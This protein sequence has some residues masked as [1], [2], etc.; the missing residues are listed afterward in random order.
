MSAVLPR[1]KPNMSEVD[2]S[3][4]ESQHMRI[5]PLGRC[6]TYEFPPGKNATCAHFPPWDIH[7]Y[8]I[9]LKIS[10]FLRPVGQA[11]FETTCNYFPS[12][13]IAIKLWEHILAKYKILCVCVCGGSQNVFVQLTLHNSVTTHA[14]TGND[15]LCS[16]WAWLSAAQ[17]EMLLRA[18][19]CLGSANGWTGL[20]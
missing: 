18:L 15:W 11:Q 2:F 3:R 13:W 4:G 7:T 12:I 10:E 8:R 19:V 1:M 16:N 6:D 17:K 5:S 9:S 14:T 20:A